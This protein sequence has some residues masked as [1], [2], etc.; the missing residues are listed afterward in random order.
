MRKSANFHNILP[1]KFRFTK[2]K[3]PM[4]GCRS[5]PPGLRPATLR[6][7]CGSG[8]RRA[9]GPPPGPARLASAAL[10]P[11]FSGTS[12]P[13]PP[14]PARLA[15]RPSGGLAPAPS[16]LRPPRSRRRRLRR[17]ARPI[18]AGALRLATGGQP[19]R[20]G[21]RAAPC[22]APPS[23]AAPGPLRLRGYRLAVL[24]PPC[25]ALRPAL[26][27]GPWPSPCVPCARLRRRRDPPGRPGLRAGILGLRASARARCAP[28]AV[29]PCGP[30][31]SAPAPGAGGWNLAACGRRQLVR[32][33]RDPTCEAPGS[34]RCTLEKS[35]ILDPEAAP[36]GRL[37]VHPT[38]PQLRPLGYAKR[39]PE[40]A[41][42][43]PLTSTLHPYSLFRHT[44]P[45]TAGKPSHRPWW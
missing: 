8:S 7:G 41:G 30:P 37:V 43:N 2:H 4:G 39:G 20:R 14:L 35:R 33:G 13:H 44:W 6:R 26:A 22:L 12:G 24:G 19:P 5:T 10:P 16:G 9:S 1:H 15:A 17:L 38:R 23:A 40:P 31:F 21:L 3:A 45:H 11:N 29:R 36:A 32:C 25:G 34:A 28:G 18:G 42:S 27:G